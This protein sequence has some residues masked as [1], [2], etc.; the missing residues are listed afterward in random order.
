MRF[1][2]GSIIRFTYKHQDVDASTGDKFK[3]VL[4][5]NPNWNNKLHAIDLKRLSPA[6]REVLEAVL[7]PEQ[8]DKPHRIPLVND[9][10][11][12]MD[13]I[14]MIRNPVAFYTKF[15]KPFLRSKDAY[16]QYIPSLMSGITKIKDASIKTGKKP[17]ANPLFGQKPGQTQTQQ[18]TA[19][20][21]P[22]TAIDVM[23]Q[24]AANRGLK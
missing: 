9:I 10:K 24:N 18:P 5:L 6:E 23:K 21:K 2:P 14:E 20:P 8:K 16:R 11:R 22:L 19:Q 15:V 13:P 1:E 17:V 4:V 3:E 12:R 7:D